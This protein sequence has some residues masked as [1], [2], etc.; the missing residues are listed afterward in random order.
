MKFTTPISVKEQEPK[1][2]HTSKILLLGS[3]FVENI[4]EKLDYYQF[5]TL[6]NPFGI[7]YHPKAIENFISKVSN[8]YVYEEKDIFFHNEQWH[9]FNAHSSLN[10]NN[11]EELLSKLNESL[12]ATRIFIE[13]ASHIIFTFGTSWYYKELKSGDSVANCH[14]IPQINFKKELLFVD[15]IIKVFNIIT[16]RL[17]TINPS[18]K[19]IFTVSPVRHIKDGLV[20]NQQSKSHLI[21]G[22]H[23][24]INSQNKDGEQRC[25]Y[26]P[27][28]EI[29]IDELRD[30][31][32]YSEDMIHPN[33]TAIGFIWDQFCNAWVA[34]KSFDL[35]KSIKS[36]QTGLMHKPFNENSESHQKFLKGIEEKISNIKKKIP[37][38]N[39]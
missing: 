14:K 19:M 9:C 13:D 25:F 21:V 37:T 7:F 16:S 26:F 8:N 28:Y 33:S 2:D 15:D 23:H 22:I 4:G 24:F 38:A 31:R 35:F 32:F 34:K 5:Q 39:F 11:K 12:R 10:S 17:L 36:I 30:Y 3:C 27:A 1:I 20:E 18:L 29:M 6:K